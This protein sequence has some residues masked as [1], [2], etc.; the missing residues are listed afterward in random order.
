[1][2]TAITLDLIS[3]PDAAPVAAPYRI[4]DEAGYSTATVKFTAT[5]DGNL[6]PGPTVYPGDG[7]VFPASSNAAAGPFPD[8]PAFYP[9]E[10]AMIPGVAQDI[11]GYVIREGGTDQTS[12]KAVEFAGSVCSAAL[13]CSSRRVCSEWGL[14]VPSGTQLTTLIPYAD[15]NDG[16]GDGAKTMNVYILTENQG[17]S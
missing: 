3:T 17:W 9:D 13:P 11:I 2:A 16:T 4:S 8:D 5:H 12:G 6:L 7:T 15:A 1:M 14:R 10:G